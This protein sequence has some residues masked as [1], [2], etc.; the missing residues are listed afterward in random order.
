MH[1]EAKGPLDKAGRNCYGGV[2]SDNYGIIF[3]SSPNKH[4]VG[5]H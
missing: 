2:F 3:S 5:T 4:V 1:K